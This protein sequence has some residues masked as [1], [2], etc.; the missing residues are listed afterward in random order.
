[1]R[2]RGAIDPGEVVVTVER[3]EGRALRPQRAADDPSCVRSRDRLVAG[4]RPH[5]KITGSSYPTAVQL[6]AQRDLGVQN[7]CAV[8]SGSSSAATRCSQALADA[9][10][11]LSDARQRRPAWSPG[12]EHVSPSLLAEASAGHCWRPL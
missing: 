7:A 8:T 6:V 4:P 10:G 11:W 3:L 1:M 12:A 5:E 2:H 9:A